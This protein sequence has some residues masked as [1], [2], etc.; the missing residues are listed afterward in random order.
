MV[1]AYYE[2]SQFKVFILSRGRSKQKQIHK[3]KITM[4]F[5]SFRKK[6]KREKN[7]MCKRMGS[8]QIWPEDTN[9][10]IKLRDLF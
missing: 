2:P 10:R 4:S 7:K 5:V 9:L 3:N 1:I 6:L 8:G